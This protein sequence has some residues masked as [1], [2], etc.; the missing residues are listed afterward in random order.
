MKEE[1][2]LEL[3]SFA[4]TFT[5]LTWLNLWLF[6]IVTTSD[7]LALPDSGNFHYYIYVKTKYRNPNFEIIPNNHLT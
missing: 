7:F 6:V 5:V 2:A 3:P 4:G 1:T